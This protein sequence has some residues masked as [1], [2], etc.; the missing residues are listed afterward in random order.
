MEKLDIT[1]DLEIDSTKYYEQAVKF[2]EEAERHLELFEL[3]GALFSYKQVLGVYEESEDQFLIA[4]TLKQIGIIQNK[5][6]ELDLSIE[7][8]NNSLDLFKT[9]SNV[10]DSKNYEMEMGNVFHYLAEAYHDNGEYDLALNNWKK[11]LPRFETSKRILETA[12]TLRHIGFILQDKGDKKSIEYFEKAISSF[13]QIDA[14]LD[15]ANLQFSI[16]LV[17]YA[18]DNYQEAIKNYEMALQYYLKT[19]N[20]YDEAETFFSLCLVY[21]KINNREKAIEY[22]LKALSQYEHNPNLAHK[23]E[24]LREIGKDF[25]SFE[26]INQSLDADLDSFIKMQESENPSIQA[27]AFQNIALIY[28]TKG[29]LQ[30]AFDYSQKCL[31]VYIDQNLLDKQGS[32]LQNLGLISHRMKKLYLAIDYYHQAIEIF[33][34]EDELVK[35][36]YNY[37]G[38]ANILL[39]RGKPDSAIEYF[40]KGLALYENNIDFLGEATILSGLGKAYRSKGEIDR[41]LEAYIK[42]LGLF[43]RSSNPL[44]EAS[45]LHY[46][47]EIYFIRSENQIALEKYNRALNIYEQN[48]NPLEK[49]KTLTGIGN[50]YRVNGEL[51]KS[52]KMYLEALDLYEGKELE[53]KAN[54]LKNIAE[55]YL[56]L[57]KHDEAI[58]HIIEA[59]NLLKHSSNPL[60][61]AI[62]LNKLGKINYA[63][64]D[65][66]KAFVFC[67]QSVELYQKS[68]NPFDIF[69]PLDEIYKYEPKKAI[70]L[71]LSSPLGINWYLVLIN[72][73]NSDGNSLNSDQWYYLWLAIS[74]W[75]DMVWTN[76]TNDTL[77]KSEFG[78][79]WRIKFL[80]EECQRRITSESFL[81]LMFGANDI[82]SDWENNYEKVRDPQEQLDPM[83]FVELPTKLQ[84]GEKYLKI[85]LNNLVKI[86]GEFTSFPS[87]VKE[88]HP[89]I[90]R[91]IIELETQWLQKFKVDH[92]FYPNSD[93]EH[94]SFQ[95]NPD[96][97]WLKDILIMDLGD[98]LVRVDKLELIYS[99]E[100]YFNTNQNN[101]PNIKTTSKRISIPIIRKNK[102]QEMQKF[103]A[104]NSNSLAV[105]IALWSIVISTIPFII[106]NGNL[107]TDAINL[108]GIYVVLSSL[109]GVILIL[110]GILWKKKNEH[111]LKE[112]ISSSNHSL[113]LET[114]LVKSEKADSIDLHDI[115]FDFSVTIDEELDIDQE[116]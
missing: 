73:I 53:E 30:K 10:E 15:V 59:M 41:A 3:E 17:Y 13:E 110:L 47:G 19:E 21:K 101:F 43:E 18:M 34:N 23:V 49:A 66:K 89:S 27:I 80:L 44:N 58:K 93:I 25:F 87:S 112:T 45:V 62:P 108:P 46:I 96:N 6:G 91:I 74:N 99:I 72:K 51:D 14:I 24:S 39:A 104:N 67:A 22:Y 42:S 52:I 94:R 54:T 57:K 103:R 106:D 36:S 113:S 50:I 71:A 29:D 90:S 78:L 9:V 77:N 83:W 69:R 75:W 98:N 7:T 79:N 85:R 56:I 48:T 2:E 88:K 81:N 102:Y 63:K 37:A 4:R 35:L 64:G 76:S 97:T 32:L 70:F 68:P 84:H 40:E 31:K 38:I 115:E 95:R 26:E 20:P 82:D 60:K 100:I 116:N 92:L 11:A 114:E 16:G 33:K 86:M 5:Q 65:M 111:I 107:I 105:F 55:A 12:K 61:I 28:K 109:G 1:D 8:L